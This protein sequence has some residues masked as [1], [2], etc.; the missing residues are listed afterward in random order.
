MSIF[1]NEHGSV[2]RSLTFREW[3][4]KLFGKQPC[5]SYIIMDGVKH[6]CS[7]TAH[8]ETVR[9][10]DENTKLTWAYGDDVY[11][12]SKRELDKYLESTYGKSTVDK[13]QDS[14]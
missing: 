2:T 11:G 12:T 10:M 3:L 4:R 6:Q 14:E 9:H 5:P 1:K 13:Q 8:N 7:F